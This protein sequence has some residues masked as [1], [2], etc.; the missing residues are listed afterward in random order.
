MRPQAM[1]EA[2]DLPKC[3]LSNYLSERLDNV[4]DNDR[5]VRA[6]RDGCPIEHVS[7]LM[8]KDIPDHGEPPTHSWCLI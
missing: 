7:P 5:R 2:K 1:L 6:E 3:D 4:L 8:L